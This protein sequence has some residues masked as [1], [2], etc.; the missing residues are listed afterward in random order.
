MKQQAVPEIWGGDCQAFDLLPSPLTF[1]L[2]ICEFIMTALAW[3]PA[4]LLAAFA[5]W[6]IVDVGAQAL[7]L[8]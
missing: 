4:F 2:V 1:G 7:G 3:L 5:V 8:W 6:F